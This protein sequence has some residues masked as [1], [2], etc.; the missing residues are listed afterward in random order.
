MLLNCHSY[1]SLGYGTLSPHAL[2]EKASK[3]GHSDLCLTDINNTSACLESLR[4][5]KDFGIRLRIGIDFRNGVKQ[6][7]IGIAK[8]NLGFM[9]L[10]RYLSAVLKSKA[11][12]P[13]RAPDF[14]HCYIVYPFNK[15]Q[16]SLLKDWEFIGVGHHELGKLKFSPLRLKPSKLVVHQEVSFS[17]KREFNTHRL[18]R[19]IHDNVLLS[20]LPPDHQAKPSENLPPYHELRSSFINHPELIY[21]TEKLLDNC[22]VQFEFGVNQNKKT[23]TGSPQADFELL[24]REC[25]KGM[26]YRFGGRPRHAVERLRHELDVLQQKEFAAY[27][28]INW[29]LVQYA[30][31]KGYPYVGRG[32]GANSLAAY[33]LRITDVEPIELDLYFE[34]FINPYRA[35][36]PD[37]DI[38]FSWTDRD[39]ITHYLFNKYGYD[40]TVL[41]GSYITFKHKSVFRELGKV[42]G[43]PGDEIE[44]IQRNPDPNQSDNYAKWIIK[45]SEYIAGLPSHLSVHAC[46]ILIAEKPIHYYCGTF[47]PPKNFPTTQFDMEVAEDVGLHKF[48]IL[49]QR[50][51]GKIYDAVKLV[52]QRHGVEID[53]HNTLMFRQDNKVKKMLKTGETIGCF[54]VESPAMRM[55]LTKL[56]ADDYLRLVAASSIIRPGVAKSGMMREY[57]IRFRDKARREKAKKELP[58]LYNILEETYGVM[59]YQE[60][61][62]KVASRFAELSLAEADIL[63]R[64]MSWNFKKRTEFAEVRDKF[65]T[66]CLKK[67]YSKKVVSEI[68]SQIETFASFAFAKGHSASYAVESFQALYLKAHYPTEYMVACINNGGGFYSRSL[69]LHEAKKFGAIVEAPCINRSDIL[70][71]IRSLNTIFIGLGM[72]QGLEFKIVEKILLE[73]NR[74]GAFLDFDDFCDRL[75]IGIEQVTLLIRVGAF[76]AFEPDKK[77]LLWRAHTLLSTESLAAE[78]TAK[79][80]APPTKNYALPQLW[81]HQLQ[82]AYDEIELLGFPLQSPWDLLKFPPSENLKASDLPDLLNKNVTLVAYLV[83]V[84][85]T[86]TSDGKIMHFGTW[87]DRQGQWIDTVHFPP[88]ASAYPFRGKGHYRISGKVVEEYDFITI[89]VAKQELL[90]VQN[91]DDQA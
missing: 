4:I 10:N 53:V 42:F 59:V 81:H 57:I 62:M 3:L 12:F 19:A 18:L 66:N 67:G 8:N 24:E 21:N 11:P 31:H 35:S 79:L 77:K 7:F 34:R 33:L 69:Y 45:Y 48:D 5:A 58:E 50:G 71:N 1:Y 86:K 17:N 65:F 14:E 88:A 49:S 41:L 85:R 13:D 60:D 51:L 32:S 25:W 16:D 78:P 23:F 72:I 90:E 38:D 83:H 22:Q 76:R 54:Y 55:L 29:D 70:C 15:M 20:K 9:E 44:K 43:L 47:V 39:D 63:R 27:F 91:L 74:N 84:K 30:L 89:E 61:V 46:G 40:H 75:S 64:G 36:P 52:K 68:W 28:L 56:K 37:F 2:L 26:D 80:F 82:D 6:Q 73:R 87:L